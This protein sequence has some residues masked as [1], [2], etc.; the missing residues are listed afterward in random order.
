MDE[1]LISENKEKQLLKG[2]L[3]V[4]P[5]VAELGLEEFVVN[6]G[7]ND[8]IGGDPTARFAVA[9]FTTLEVEG[10]DFYIHELRQLKKEVNSNGMTILLQESF[11]LPTTLPSIMSNHNVPRNI[12]F[13]KVDIDS[14]DCVIVNQT[15]TLGFRPAFLQMEVHERRPF[16][17]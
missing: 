16:D 13:M 7:A 10:A 2:R 14:I 9:G 3:A 1:I 8:G 15:L 11:V 4:S 6:F 12:A 5:L 17:S